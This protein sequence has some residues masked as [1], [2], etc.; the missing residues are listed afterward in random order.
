MDWRD[1]VK[2]TGLSELK[3]IT[4]GEPST[5]LS[6]FLNRSFIKHMLQDVSSE[7]ELIII[8]TSPVLISNINNVDPVYLST[9]CDMVILVVQDKMTTKAM[10]VDAVDSIRDGGG[11]VDAIVYNHQL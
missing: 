5:E 2:N 10:L 7:F 1:A 11:D 3:V 8:D 4:A 6:F 9:L